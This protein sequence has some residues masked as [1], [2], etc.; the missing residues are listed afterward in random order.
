MMKKYSK[1]ARLGL[2]AS[3]L[4]VVVLAMGWRSDEFIMR[5][6]WLLGAD[7]LPQIQHALEP[8]TIAWSEVHWSGDIQEPLLNESSGLAASNRHED[9]LWSINDSGDGPNLF[10]MSTTGIARG[11]WQ[12]AT[13]TPTD[14]EAMSS[15]Q[16][17]GESY[18]L[19][20]DVGDNFATRS[21]VSFLVV[22]EPSLEQDQS[23]LIPVEWGGE[24][25]Y[26]DGPRDCEA[27]AVDIVN[28]EV[29]FL[30]KRTFPNE[31]YSVPLRSSAD[32]PLIA[33]K[34]SDLYPLP[35]N[36]P[37]HGKLYG[38]SAKYQGM[39][40]GMSLRGNRLL[41]VTYRDAYLY[42]LLD[43]AREPLRIPLPLV[44]QREAIAFAKDSDSLAFV[45][46]ERKRGEEVADLFS[47]RFALDAL[48]QMPEV[49]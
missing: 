22:R 36:V 38:R 4:I 28:E 46:R 12:I 33:S 49:E 17:N 32:R 39:P 9:L 29:L 43:V 18:L 7:N 1:K 24:F 16:L 45:S 13:A 15:F 26:P 19:V 44:G 21:T 3:F 31:L 2:G 5:T 25:V 27:V 37:E 11:Q 14:W 35:R 42:D 41:V 23:V 30:S 47:V 40:T 10:A 6:V 34:V 8:T 48:G 20:A